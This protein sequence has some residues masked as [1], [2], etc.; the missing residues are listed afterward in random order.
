MTVN[1]IG[2]DVHSKTTNFAVE[3]KGQIIK[4]F[5]IP[6]SLA[7]WRDVLKEIPGEKKLVIEEGTMAGW[8][9][10]NLKDTVDEFIVCDPRR[11]SL[12]TQDGDKTDEIDARKLAE[13]LRGVHLPRSVRE[14]P[15]RCDEWLAKQ[16]LAWA[17]NGRLKDVAIGM[18]TSAINQRKNVFY[19]YYERML[20]AGIC[21]VR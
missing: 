20:K 16:Q 21:Y 6:T 17:V 3:R 1:Y 9:Y 19:C 11:N 15:Q 2:A 4:E 12:I 10:R 14:S 8:L 7:A 5:C 13:L 18:A